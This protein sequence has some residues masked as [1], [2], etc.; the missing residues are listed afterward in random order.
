LVEKTSESRKWRAARAVK[1]LFKEFENRLGEVVSMQRIAASESR[2]EGARAI[3][4]LKELALSAREL[5][6]TQRQLLTRIERDWQLHI[7]GNAQRAGEAQAKAFGESIAQ[8]LHERLAELAI[9]VEATTRRL[10]WKVVLG[11]ALGIAIAIP[12]SISVGVQSFAPSVEKLSVAGLTP[13]Q[14]SDALS[15]V[16]RCRINKN[17]WHDWHVCIAVDDSPRLTK[18]AS[19][20]ALVVLRGM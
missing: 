18:G 11:W 7:D 16:V 17:D 20:E 2:A 12:L 13:E 5:V 19:G 14:T 4:Q 15:R 6:G 8:G 1:E 10:S 3:Q 9:Q